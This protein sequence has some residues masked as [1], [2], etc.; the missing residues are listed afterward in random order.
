M[1]NMPRSSMHAHVFFSSLNGPPAPGAAPTLPPTCAR[2]QEG[3][4][5][6][7][8]DGPDAKRPPCGRG[9]QEGD[10]P[11]QGGARTAL[12]EGDSPPPPGGPPRSSPPI[13]APAPRGE[14]TLRGGL[15]G[16]QLVLGRAALGHG[17]NKLAGSASERFSEPRRAPLLACLP[18]PPS[19]ALAHG[20]CL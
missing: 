15:L 13:R 20:L 12:Q 16:L 5:R 19:R 17:G 11:P 1:Q 7:R 6:G 4:V 3:V 18:L 10:A 9:A 8:T 2:R 14:G